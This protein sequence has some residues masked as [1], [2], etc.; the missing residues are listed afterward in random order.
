MKRAT[1]LNSDRI[2]TVSTCHQR[3]ARDDPLLSRNG[4][5][6]RSNVPFF[7]EKSRQESTKMDSDGLRLAAADLDLI[8]NGQ[9]IDRVA[10][11]VSSKLF[12]VIGRCLT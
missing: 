6:E 9:I 4:E 3:V 5:D 11:R 10:N 7:T 2:V 12:I 1:F 8:L